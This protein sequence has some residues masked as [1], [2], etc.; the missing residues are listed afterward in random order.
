MSAIV[1]NIEN[2]HPFLDSQI[3]RIARNNVNCKEIFTLVFVKAKKELMLQALE[4]LKI[5]LRDSDVIFF[6]QDH[7]FLVLPQTDSSGGLH[8]EEIL[9]EFLNERK[10][11]LTIATLNEHGKTKNELFD[12]IERVCQSSY[13]VNFKEDYYKNI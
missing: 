2:L 12:A 8:I 6:N 7:L 5:N 13:E 4:V 1:M 11:C 3:S 9:K 10:L